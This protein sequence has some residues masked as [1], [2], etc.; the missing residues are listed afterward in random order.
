[1]GLESV[2]ASE[3][4]IGDLTYTFA[5]TGVLNKTP[6]NMALCDRPAMTLYILIKPMF[7]EITRS[8]D[9]SNVMQHDGQHIC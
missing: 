6:A 3:D 7:V 4:V 5:Q 9:K 1:M 2:S 8:R